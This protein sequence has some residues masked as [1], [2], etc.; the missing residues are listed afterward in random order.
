MTQTT[1]GTGPG[2]ASNVFPSLHNGRVK[3]ANLTNEVVDFIND[4]YPQ[5]NIADNNHELELSDA[6]K[7]IYATDCTVSVPYDA[8]VPF[9]IG[10]QIIVV[11]GGIDVVIDKAGGATAVYF[12]GSDETSF[13]VA[14]RSLATLLKTGVDEWYIYGD[15]ITV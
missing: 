15:S 5:V 14:A 12:E 11:A 3:L 13:T 7:H 1:E 8:D 9:P 4:G 2:S 10:T 6:N